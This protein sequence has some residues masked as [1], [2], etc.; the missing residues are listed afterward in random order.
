MISENTTAHLEIL[1]NSGVPVNPDIPVH[2]TF[3]YESLWAFMTLIVLWVVIR[4]HKCDG[5]IFC[6]YGALYGLGRFWIEALRTDSLMLGFVRVSQLVA[7]LSVVVFG[8]LYFAL[9]KRKIREK[10]TE[11]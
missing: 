8:I 6:A 3:L 11:F 7:L 1:K 4:K 5:Q 10:L 2:P 9:P